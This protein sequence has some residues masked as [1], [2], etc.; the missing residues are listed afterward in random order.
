MA[1]IIAAR[2][3]WF[4]RLKPRNAASLVT[5]LRLN[6]KTGKQMKREEPALRREVS[7]S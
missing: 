5:A 6:G 2:S 7:P 3:S 4:T 1:M